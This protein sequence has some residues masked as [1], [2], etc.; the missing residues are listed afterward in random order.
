MVRAVTPRRLV[1][2]VLL[3]ASFIGVVF[4][5]TTS[6]D[7]EPP[8]VQ[9]E[10]VVRVFP[11]EG[12]INVRQDAIGVELAFGYTGV[13]QVD[14]VEI[15]EDQLDRIAGINRISYTPGPGKEIGALAPG[16]HCATTVFWRQSE[17]REQ[18]RTYTWCFTSA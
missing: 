18:A 5:F 3:A 13:I 17:S 4:A 10:A 12:D 2:W 7:E 16:R 15:P 11:Q 1:I 9:D 6:R 8:R 14:R